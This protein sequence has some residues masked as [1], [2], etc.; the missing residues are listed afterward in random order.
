MNSWVNVAEVWRGD[1][2]ECVHRGRAVVCDARGAV[3][4]EWGDSSAVTLPRSSSKML[5][6]LPLIESGAAAKFGLSTQQL[7]L[8]CASHQGAH[9]HTDRVDV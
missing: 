5:Q 8:S 7:A 6:A 4:A 1:F 2:L 9:I 3:V